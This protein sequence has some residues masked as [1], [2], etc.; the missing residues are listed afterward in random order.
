MS[1]QNETVNNSALILEGMYKGIVGKV[2][3]TKT[4]VKQEMAFSAAQQLSAYEALQENV[5]RKIEAVIVELKFLLQ[6]N[7][8]IYDNNESA[9][10]ENR[11]Q[12]MAAVEE[13]A[14]AIEK[15]LE[16]TKLDL[17]TAVRL[18]VS[19]QVSVAQKQMEETKNEILEA[20]RA[21]AYAVPQIDYDLIATKVQDAIFADEEEIVEEEEA[22]EELIDYDILAEKI[23]SILPE[24]DTDALVEKISAILPAETDYD[25]IAE[26]VATVIPQIDY[27]TLADKLAAAVPET[28]YDLIAE[29]VKESLKEEEVEEVADEEIEEEVEEEVIELDYDALC[30]QI[31]QKVVEE[32]RAEQL[33]ADDVA[34]RLAKA[35]P[36]TDYDLIATAI[37]AKM[38]AKEEDDNTDALAE[39][40]SGN[41]VSA[42]ADQFDVTVDEEG[43]ARIAD[44]VVQ[45][46][47]YDTIAEKVAELLKADEGDLVR[48]ITATAPVEEKVETV[49]EPVEEGV[50]EVAEEPVEE[51]VEE[52]VEEVV[53]E[54]PAEEPQAEEAEELA[55]AETNDDEDEDDN[56][57]GVEETVNDPSMTLRYKRSFIAKITQS[58]ENVKDF[59][60]DVKNA[61]LGYEKVRS[62]VSWAGDRFT[63][64]RE[65]LAKIGIR[66]KTLCLYLALNPD[67]FPITVYHQKFAGDTKMYE[68]TPMMIK[69]KSNV[70]L[71]RALRLID[72]IMER[73]GAEAK[74]DAQ[75][76]DYTKM[77]KYKSDKKLLAEGLIK[78]AMVEKTSM[79]F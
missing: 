57:E 35:I 56:R 31:A 60:S 13:R 46:L 26:K 8:A 30:E 12:I 77:Y 14:Q 29:K 34:E 75:P 47:N 74:K 53:E 72:Y 52:V 76:V 51:A 63:R 9:R 16:E 61:F 54:E 3:E 66:G 70:A 27:D 21:V 23:V 17:L 7:S 49:E 43:I 22:Q 37:V 18:A 50:E 20:V 79:N 58:D 32:L 73:E 39:A 2:D 28:D 15:K 5:D 48:I 36:E 25:A 24:N 62:Q 19:E 64:G 1:G 10:K 40:V 59:Y 38:P 44:A 6:Q 41:V 55:V 67:E 68:K 71:K 33:D 78:T 69:I 65:T 4:A 45:S 42:I 11:D